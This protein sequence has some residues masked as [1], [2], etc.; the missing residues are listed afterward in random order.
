[1]GWAGCVGK[2]AIDGVRLRVSV[3]ARLVEEQQVSTCDLSACL[4]RLQLTLDVRRVDDRHDAVET[5]RRLELIIEP[6]RRRNRTWV[7]H[8]GRLLARDL[9]AREGRLWR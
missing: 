3:W 7:R 6:K 8:P 1:M 9:G 5:Q 2:M 4:E